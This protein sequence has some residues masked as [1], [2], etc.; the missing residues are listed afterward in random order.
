V[1]EKQKIDDVDRVLKWNFPGVEESGF[2][3]SAVDWSEIAE[4]VSAARKIICR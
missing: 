1:A 4:A 2:D 3:W